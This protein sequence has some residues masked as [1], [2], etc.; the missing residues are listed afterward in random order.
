MMMDW[1]QYHKEIGARIGDLMKLSVRVSQ[2]GGH[3]GDVL[4]TVVDG[5]GTAGGHDRRAGG[6]IPI[7][8]ASSAAVDALLR[9]VRARFLAS[10]KVDDPGQRL[11]E[12][13]PH[14]PVP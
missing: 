9:D 4:R 8:D 14:I 11:L 6:A 5:L 13:S 2:L 10:L 7:A 1:N 12:T 3:S